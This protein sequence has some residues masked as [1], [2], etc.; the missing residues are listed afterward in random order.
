MFAVLEFLAQKY[1]NFPFF[2][3]LL[4]YQAFRRVKNYK[5]KPRKSGREFG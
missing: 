3:V 4:D 5:F 1:K 2:L